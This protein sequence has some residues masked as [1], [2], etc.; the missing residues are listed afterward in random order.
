MAYFIFAGKW[1]VISSKIFEYL[2]N[3]PL[4]KQ[5]W[6]IP[7][8]W[9]LGNVVFIY[10]LAQDAGFDTV[11]ASTDSLVNNILLAAFCT[12]AAFA[13]RYYRPRP[14]QSLYLLIGIIVLA[15]L[16]NWISNQVLSEVLKNE[17]GYSD[18]LLKTT[19]IRL[20]NSILLI[21]LFVLIGWVSFYIEEQ[22]EEKNRNQEIAKM[23]K[24]AELNNLRQQL[25][26]HFLFNTLNSI[27]ALAGTQ[28]EMAKKMIHQLSDFLR[29]TINQTNEKEYFARKKLNTY[30]FIFQ[31]KRS[32]LEIGSI[33]L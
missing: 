9:W 31:L 4:Q 19:A 30:H 6:L 2:S 7:V 1:S 3:F 33:P 26:P 20:F 12:G 15:F 21:S 17:N 14:E 23:S 32:D 29:R 28:P 18:F 13:V 11:I 5:F 22:F 25:Q 24:E 27:S 8:I 16:W 10:W